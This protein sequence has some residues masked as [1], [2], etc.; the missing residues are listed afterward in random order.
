M[1]KID[2][3]KKIRELNRQDIENLNQAMGLKPDGSGP[4]PKNDKGEIIF[5]GDPI[6]STDLW[7]YM[8]ASYGY[9]GSSDGYHATSPNMKNYILRVLDNM[10]V[11]IAK[12]AQELMLQDI[13]AARKAAEDEA[14][15]V[16]GM[17]EEDKN[18]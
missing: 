7:I 5:C 1:S 13:E 18:G 12:Q 3:Y 6:W 10:K 4:D 9:Y 16:L 8:H 11:D 2:E 17:V 14:R 15:E